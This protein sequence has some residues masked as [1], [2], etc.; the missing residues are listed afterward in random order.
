M[1]SEQWLSNNSYSLMH[2]KVPITMLIATTTFLLIMLIDK[3]LIGHSHNHDHPLSLQEETDPPPPEHEGEGNDKELN[4]DN[5]KDI[6][7]EKDIGLNKDRELPIV[8][9][10]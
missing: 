5:D 2:G 7:K 8:E 10:V 4:K 6:S 1:L 3:V 9:A